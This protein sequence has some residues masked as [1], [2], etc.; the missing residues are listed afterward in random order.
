MIIQDK[1]MLTWNLNW[2]LDTEFIADKYMELFM[3][4]ACLMMGYGCTDVH[5][6]HVMIK[7]LIESLHILSSLRS[8]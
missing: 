7:A 8:G 5:V 6:C 4:Y 2:N 1:L 3:N